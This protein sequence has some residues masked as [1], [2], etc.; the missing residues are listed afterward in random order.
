MTGYN[1]FFKIYVYIIIH[2]VY[3]H[4]FSTEFLLFDVWPVSQLLWF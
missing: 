1:T 4:K 2:L 3:V